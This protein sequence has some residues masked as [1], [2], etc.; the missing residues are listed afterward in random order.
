MRDK[1]TDILKKYYGY[2]NFRDKQLD[3]IESILKRRDTLAVMPTGAGKSICFQ[4]PGML[5]EGITLVISPLISLMKDQTDALHSIGIPSTFINSSL[6]FVETE[7]RV[8]RIRDG[9]IKL[10]YI[11]PERLESGRFLRLLKGIDV[12]L[13]AVDEA[14]CVSQWGHDFRPSYT[15]IASLIQSFEIRPVVAAFTATATKQ[16]REDIVDL[17]KLQQPRIFVTGFDRK[18]LY[19]SVIKHENK[20][21]FILKYIK[22][23]PNK[24]GIVY[25]ATRKQVDS[26]YQGLKKK[27][28][29][30]GKY[31]AGLRDEYR[32][33]VQEAFL[34]DDINIMVATNAFGMG[35]DK[36]NVR[37]VIHYN[38]PKNVESYYQEAG[39]AG[40]DGEPGD[41][42]VLF[43]P[44][45]VTI[46]KYLIEQSGLSSQRKTIEYKRLQAIVDYCHTSICLR[47]YILQY[48]GEKDVPDNCS[49]CS[50][51]NDD[52]EIVDITINAQKIFSCIVRAG[53]NFGA[54]VI[55]QV[56]KGSK[57][58]R[59]KSLGL[60]NLSTYGIMKGYT[61]KEIK[62]MINMLIADDYIYAETGEYPVLKLRS[63]SLPV[64][65]GKNKVLRR[66]AVKR[67]DLQPEEELFQMLRE[68]RRNL[69][70]REK[71]P[72]YIIF[73][74][75]TLKEM[76]AY[77][78][79]DRHSLLDI[80]GVGE[81]KLERYGEYFLAAIKK[82]KQEKTG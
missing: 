58:K 45:D 21:D 70:Q 80:R 23:N 57:S 33:Q 14:H 30:V 4:I 74:D 61:L 43:S 41:C 50:I 63:K 37:F 31:H 75:S 44:G 81:V 8:D 72:P 28:Y 54:T 48:F 32:D 46:Q 13:I 79:Q 19:Y 11:A 35:I 56:L 22:D 59:I 7:E 1:A 82:Y 17:L 76:S 29:K 9:K 53:G 34:Y 67:E 18:N 64:L 42:I 20:N 10:L 51:C 36:S 71:V 40:R 73:S 55:A 2:S 12:S 5:F 69:A 39:R 16:V 77:M 47:K 49:N 66:I 6:S 62:D 27:G 25:A 15:S 3:I 52:A 78:P 60:N 68:V 38:I 24:S 65:K 26:L